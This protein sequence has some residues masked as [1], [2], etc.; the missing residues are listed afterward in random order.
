MQTYNLTGEYKIVL[1][2]LG[3]TDP[4]QE[5]HNV[6]CQIKKGDEIIIDNSDLFA[7][8][9]HAPESIDT[10]CAFLDFLENEIEIYNPADPNSL[11]KILNT[12]KKMIWAQR[13]NNAGLLY[14]WYFDLDDPEYNL[15]EDHWKN[16]IDSIFDA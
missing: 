3:Y 6:L 2:D 12:R 8:P 11:A 1:T 14:Y 4:K 5:K 15:D 9:L 13:I 7:S 10:A 16:S